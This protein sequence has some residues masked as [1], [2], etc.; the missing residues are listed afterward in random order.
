[1]FILYYAVKYKQKYFYIWYTFPDPTGPIIITN[2]PGIIFKLIFS[3]ELTV[4][5]SLH[6]AVTFLKDMLK[7]L[8][9]WPI[10][11][12]LLLFVIVLLSLKFW[13]ANVVCEVFIDL[14]SISSSKRKS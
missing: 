1:M 12:S 3:K 6:L 5:E 7:S 10:L 9:S 4:W 11:L 13:R 14:V 2:W 8:D